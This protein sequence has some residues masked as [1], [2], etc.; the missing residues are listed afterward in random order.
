MNFNNNEMITSTQQL[1]ITKIFEIK[2]PE[3]PILCFNNEL[4]PIFDEVKTV[5]KNPNRELL[6][7]KLV[8]RNGFLC[9][10]ISQL[11]DFSFSSSPKL[12]H[13]IISIPLIR[14]SD[15]IIFVLYVYYSYIE[16][17]IKFELNKNIDVL[18]LI[19]QANCKFLKCS[20]F[21]SMSQTLFVCAFS[22]Y[23]SLDNMPSFT[24]YIVPLRSFFHEVVNFTS[25]STFLLDA[26]INKLMITRLPKTEMENENIIFN[27][28]LNNN[29]HEYKIEMYALL[30]MI[31]LERGNSI[32]LNFTSMIMKA[33]IPEMESLNLG[34]LNLLV[35]CSRCIPSNE[36]GN[37]LGIIVDSLMCYI[38]SSNL[39]FS[40]NTKSNTDLIYFKFEE[41]EPIFE[42]T[43]CTF[44]NGFKYFNQNTFIESDSLSSYCENELICKLGLVSQSLENHIQLLNNFVDIYC[45]KIK[46]LKFISSQVY[47]HILVLFLICNNITSTFS[48]EIPCI[49]NLLI[50]DLIFNPKVIYQSNDLQMKSLTSLRN[51]A[52]LLGFCSGKESFSKIL[53]FLASY[54][55]LFEECMIRIL[56]FHDNQIKRKSSSFSIENVL[57]KIL[58]FYRILEVNGNESVSESRSYIIQY[59]VRNKNYDYFYQKDNYFSNTLLGIIFE[60]NIKDMIF[61]QIDDIMCQQGILTIA[62]DHLAIL[63][64]SINDM[65]PTYDT[66]DLLCSLLNA[67]NKAI[68]RSHLQLPVFKKVAYSLIQNLESIRTSSL[69]N[70]DNLNIAEEF[71][72]ILMRFFA[73]TSSSVSFDIEIF[74]IQSNYLIFTSFVRFHSNF[75]EKNVY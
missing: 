56:W 33:I 49:S 55:K 44:K 54:P 32:P 25:E 58:N 22:L 9:T 14:K 12:L 52:L 18:P 27:Q 20:D 75:C 51:C 46:E 35:S 36:F 61:I 45:C 24:H 43:D 64:D 63:I 19:L 26:I 62:F 38:E 29:I 53:L 8:K 7:T 34:A 47:S 17:L 10:Q 5:Q 11:G 41:V 72:M 66:T 4:K 67:Y 30:S 2:L 69:F 74:K 50:D 59:F 71:L 6:I 65:S 48:V 3:Y 13:E 57:A 73:I 15:T 37:Y 68:A 21:S 1:L 16:W 31:C 70:G 23:L 40:V 39:M 60:K 28:D 42:F